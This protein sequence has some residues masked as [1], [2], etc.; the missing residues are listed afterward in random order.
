MAHN[1]T[2]PHHMNRK[3]KIISIVAGCIAFAVF[4]FYLFFLNHVGANSFGVAYN[5]IGGTI[6]IQEHPGW[7]LTSPTVRT[8]DITT[9]PV[10]VTIPSGAN[11]I[12]AKLVRFKREG[13]E[14][15][16][17]LQGFGW[18]MGSNLENTLL[19]YAYAGVD[20]SFLEVVQD[21]RPIMDT[22]VAK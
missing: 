1:Q 6:Y 11:L 9:L 17:H 5:S 15:Y 3:L 10:K 19:G 22:K 20:Y 16:I 2:Q 14:E 4:G 7:Y 18:S 21:M 12:N 8:A 13:I